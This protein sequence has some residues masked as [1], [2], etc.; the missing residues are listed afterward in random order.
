MEGYKYVPWSKYLVL[1]NNVRHDDRYKEVGKITMTEDCDD[2]YMSILRSVV[3]G[4]HADR[5]H[6]MINE[7]S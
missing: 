6:L 2:A 4:C 5:Q 1:S 3:S 7:I